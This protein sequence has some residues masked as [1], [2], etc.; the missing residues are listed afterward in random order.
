MVCFAQIPAFFVY[1][2]CLLAYQMKHSFKS[3]GKKQQ[4]LIAYVPLE[5]K[6]QWILLWGFSVWCWNTFSPSYVTHRLNFKRSI[7]P[8]HKCPLSAVPCGR[9]AIC[10]PC[11]RIQPIAHK[12]RTTV[13]NVAWQLPLSL[14]KE[15]AVT[16]RNP[17]WPGWLKAGWIDTK[18]AE[19]VLNLNPS[20]PKGIGNY[21]GLS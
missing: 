9:N 12:P 4:Q 21:L 15:S 20:E 10:D 7:L 6:I 16:K 14:Q 18:P 17:Y 1:L 13:G 2:S 19:A 3:T 5:R 8:P 11:I